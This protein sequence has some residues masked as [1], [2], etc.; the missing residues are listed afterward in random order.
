MYLLFS[1]K[2]S[3]DVNPRTTFPSLNYIQQSSFSLHFFSLWVV[4]SFLVVKAR[5]VAWLRKRLCER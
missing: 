3:S 1:T 2:L 5:G 4:H